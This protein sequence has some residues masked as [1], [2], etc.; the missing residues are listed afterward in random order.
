MRVGVGVAGF[1]VRVLVAVGVFVMG[2]MVGEAG[3]VGGMAVGLVIG[4]SDSR[5]ATWT[6]VVTAGGITANPQDCMKSTRIHP[7]VQILR[8]DGVYHK[9][10]PG[11]YLSI[12]LDPR[13]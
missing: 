4:A 13:E 3:L 5:T 1:G 2:L 7:I 9:K 10:F 12:I 8:T 11:A 6:G